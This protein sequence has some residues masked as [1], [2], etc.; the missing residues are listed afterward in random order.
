MWG[1]SFDTKRSNGKQ[2]LI[3]GITSNLEVELILKHGAQSK[4][5]MLSVKIWILKDI[6]VVL[7]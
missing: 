3:V 4:R 1:Q 2:K 6:F 5:L 7:C